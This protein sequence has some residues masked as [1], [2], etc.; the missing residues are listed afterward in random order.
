[1]ATFNKKFRYRFDNFMA[2]GG[3]SIFI[4]LFVVFLAGLIFLAGI[5]LGIYGASEAPSDERKMGFFGQ[6][7][8]TFLQMTDPGN[9]AQDVKSS[10]GFKIAAILAGAVGVVIFSMLIGLIT[11]A[12]DQKMA[13]CARGIRR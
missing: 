13:R 12:L 11:T 6:V 4:S 9:M 5:R 3:K 10:T 7:C 8:I 1:M 2:K